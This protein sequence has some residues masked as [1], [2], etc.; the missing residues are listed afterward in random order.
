MWA[1]VRTALHVEAPDG[2][3][4]DQLRDWMDVRHASIIGSGLDA[5]LCRHA[6]AS[7]PGRDEDALADAS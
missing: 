1:F 7:Y 2:F 4:V 3:V 5:T 6:P